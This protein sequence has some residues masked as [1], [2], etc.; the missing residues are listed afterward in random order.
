M[1]DSKDALRGT[2]RSVLIV[3]WGGVL[4]IPVRDAIAEWIRLERI[5]ADHYIALARSWIAGATPSGATVATVDGAV[6]TNLIHR[7]EEGRLDP[8][9]F[10]RTLAAHLRTVDGRE[11]AATGLLTRMFAGFRPMPEMYDVLRRARAAG[12]RTG[13]LSNS[14][15]NPYPRDDFAELF[16]AVVISAEVGMRKPDAEIYHHTLERVGASPD[17]AVFVDDT[18]VNVRAAEALG[19][20]GI[21]HREMP[22]TV[23]RLEELLAVP[24]S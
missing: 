22:E 3:D 10:E 19:I 6:H 7:L 14:W 24:L 20:A 5:D 21:H 2:A 16:D 23:R 12:V 8:A 9:E 1:A 15:G 11:V 4:T 18:M 13:L 17:A